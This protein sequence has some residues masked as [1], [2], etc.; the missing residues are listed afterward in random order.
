M[1]WV[2][3]TAFAIVGIGLAELAV[4]EWSGRY[5][6]RASMTA[7][8]ALDYKDRRIILML[9]NTGRR[10]ARNLRYR[11]VMGEGFEESDYEKF[12]CYLEWDVWSARF[13]ML[14]ERP[15]EFWIVH[16]F[17]SQM[18]KGETLPV[19]FVEMEWKGLFKDQTETVEIDM[20][21]LTSLTWS[22]D[23]GQ[24]V[25]RKIRD[26]H[27]MFSNI[28][29]AAEQVLGYFGRLQLEGYH[30]HHAIQCLKCDEPLSEHW[31]KKGVNYETTMC[32]RSVRSIEKDRKESR[33]KYEEK[34]RLE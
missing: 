3:I 10:P 19:F 27:K 31:F 6:E 15:L 5:R 29:K 18:E 30:S 13:V 33:R 22:D 20:K 23:V 28:S 25:L 21:F 8:P 26:E 16:F 4:R 24:S 12:S 1:D 11:F 34:H 17:Q 14:P 7:A 32:P 9:A 2:M